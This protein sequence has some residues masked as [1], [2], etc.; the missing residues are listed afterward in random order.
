MSGKIDYENLKFELWEHEH[1]TKMYESWYDNG[2]WDEGKIVPYHDIS[3]SPSA[4]VLNYG[5]GI[6]EG[7]KAYKTIKG[8]IVMFRPEENAKRFVRSAERMAIP[9]LTA[10]KFMDAAVGMVKANKEFIPDSHDGKYSMYMRPLCI[11]TEPLLGVRAATQFLFTIFAAPVGPY[12]DKVGIVKLQVRDAHRAAPKGTG[13]A[14]AV[15]NYAGTMQPKKEA[16]KEGF[17]D[18]LYL[19][20]RYDKYI[21]EAGAAN[22][23]ALMK[24]GTLMTPQ[25]GTI[26]PGITRDSVIQLARKEYGINVVETDVD[27]EEVVNNAVECFVTGTAAIITSVSH[28]GYNS[29]TYDITANDYQ[30]AHKLYTHLADIQLQKKEDKYDWIFE[31]K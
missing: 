8:N 7:M 25:L 27:I 12:F 17:N 1:L 6:F 15:S 31:V 28:I 29:K 4:N 24:D 10:E 21:D 2:S 26:L 14:K 20:P 22:F 11:G 19:D 30:L 18:V 13:Y 9:G 5:Q 3:L 16:Q 23:F